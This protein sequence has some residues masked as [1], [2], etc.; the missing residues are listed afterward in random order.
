M[1]LYLSLPCMLTCAVA[2]L[3][4]RSLPK[5]SNMS[6]HDDEVKAKIPFGCAFHVR[7]GTRS[8]QLGLVVTIFS[9]AGPSD[10]LPTRSRWTH[11]ITRSWLDTPTAIWMAT[12]APVAMTSSWWN[13]TAPALGS[14]PPYMGDPP[15]IKPTLFRRGPKET[16]WLFFWKAGHT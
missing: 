10:A 16:R 6:Q 5:S 9:R 11:R 12:P 8:S 13:S 2:R 3:V 4:F 7:C 1:I 15:M 14:G